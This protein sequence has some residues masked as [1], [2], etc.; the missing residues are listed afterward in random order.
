M[1]P[2][3]SLI[4]VDLGEQSYT[5]VVREGLFDSGEWAARIVPLIAPG[6]GVMVVSDERVWALHG[7]VFDAPEWKAAVP[8][9][10]APGHA[11]LLEPGETNKNL[12]TLGA[13]YDAFAEAGL[14]RGGLVV[15]FGGGVPGD[16]GGFA[17]ATWMRGVRFVQ[18]PTTLLAMA[19]SSVGGKTGVDIPG[20]KNLVGA[21]HQPSLVLCDPAF[22][23]TLPEREY[24]S[25]M[26]EV[27]K[28]GAIASEDLFQETGQGGQ[29]RAETLGKCIRFKAEVVAEDERERGRRRILNFG[30][31]LGHAIEAKYR[32]EKYT[33][34]EAVAAGMRLAV[35]LGER[36]GVTE[37]G[38]GERLREVLARQGILIEETSEGLLDYMKR[39]KKAVGKGVNLVLLRRIGEPVIVP[40]GFGELGRL[41]KEM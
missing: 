21:F 41:M 25:G 14:S 12:S 30:H 28:T 23:K 37:R 2:E 16:L 17:A 11:A 22:L 19:D 34:G 36:I 6:E 4:V 9:W 20:G 26:A 27:I 35:L 10:R 1:A 13:I 39:D 40:M 38:T 3:D 33:H 15:T 32:F 5:V 29:I 18:I 8:L 31:T 24:R 7:G